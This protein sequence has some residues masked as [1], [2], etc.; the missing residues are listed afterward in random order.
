MYSPERASQSIPHSLTIHYQS[1]LC[2]PQ[3]IAH[4]KPP[5]QNYPPPPQPGI[6]ANTTLASPVLPGGASAFW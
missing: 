5:Q 1:Q 2:F 4:Q 6:N 3:Y